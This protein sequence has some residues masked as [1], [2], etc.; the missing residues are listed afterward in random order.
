MEGSATEPASAPPPPPQPPRSHWSAGRVI[1]MVFTGIG[2]LIGLVLLVG[3]IAVLAAYA[4]ARD[5]DGYFKTDR[6]RLE[7]PGYAIATGDIDLGGEATDWAP[8]EVLG[9]VRV[10]VEGDGPIFAGIASDA[11]VARYLEGVG[12]DEVTDFEHGDPSY[13][14]HSGGAPKTKPD[15]Q[16]FWVAEA[17]GAGEQELSW[18]AEF[19]HWTAVVMNADAGRGVNVEADAGVKLDWAIWAGLGL[20]VVGLVMTVGAVAVTLLLSRRASR[21][22]AAARA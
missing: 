16:D 22:P 20:L 11:D 2:G 18:D 3:G 8:D 4:F 17:E 7:S 15:K 9:N 21:D 10:R 6:E 5:D 19:G 12:Y 13:E 1:G 14:Q